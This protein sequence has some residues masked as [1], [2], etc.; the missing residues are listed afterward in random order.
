[1]RKRKTRKVSLAKRIL[2]IL[3]DSWMSLDDIC[4]T[5][6]GYGYTDGGKIVQSELQKKVRNA[7]SNTVKLGLENNIIVC[8]KRKPCQGD[9]RKKFIILAWKK[10]GDGDEGL[11]FDELMYKRGMGS[12][13]I[14]AFN[15]LANKVVQLE[16]FPAEKLLELNQN[17]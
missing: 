10:V 17:N 7:M 15:N 16:L 3:D 13:H 6:Y 1:M 11:I 4:E 14:K 2:N 12:S 9:A 8:P 5:L